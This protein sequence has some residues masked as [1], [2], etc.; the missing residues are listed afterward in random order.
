M[1]NFLFCQTQKH[2]ALLD[3][4]KKKNI[5][6]KSQKGILQR[7]MKCFSWFRVFC[8][9][10]T[11]GFLFLAQAHEGCQGASTPQLYFMGLQTQTFENGFQKIHYLHN[12][13]VLQTTFFVYVIHVFVVYTDDNCTVHF[14]THFQKFVFRPPKCSCCVIEFSKRIVFFY[15]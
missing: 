3:N 14:E 6:N 12:N 2:Q 5:R 10:F 7:D 13:N 9:H 11:P 4:N 15:F 1:C 8:N